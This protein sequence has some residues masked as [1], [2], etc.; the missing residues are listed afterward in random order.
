LRYRSGGDMKHLGLFVLSEGDRYQELQLA[1]DDLRPRRAP[2]SPEDGLD[3]WGFMMRTADR[4]L[5]LLYFEA[6]A[7]RPRVTG[8]APGARYAWGWYDPR[9][10]TWASE[11]ILASDSSGVIEAPPFPPAGER[12]TSDWAAKLKAAP[13]RP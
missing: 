3:G 6:G 5:A 9:E 12:A 2:D 1:S 10:G 7:A 11:Q 4:T 8:L 13:A